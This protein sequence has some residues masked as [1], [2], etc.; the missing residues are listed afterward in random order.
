MTMDANVLVEL[1]DRPDPL[2]PSPLRN[3]FIFISCAEP[4]GLT[5]KILFLLISEM[6]EAT[7]YQ[8]RT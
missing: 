3:T 5:L 7:D 1:V 4:Q 8:H 6:A 2:P